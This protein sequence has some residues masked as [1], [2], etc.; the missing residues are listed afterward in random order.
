MKE[1]LPLQKGTGSEELPWKTEPEFSCSEKEALGQRFTCK[2]GGLM[3]I[4]D[5]QLQATSQ[6]AGG[7]GV[8]AVTP[9]QSS[10][11]TG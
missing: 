2:G 8:T 5:A 11:G 4:R 1:T 3:E 7:G 6:T 9:L 10:C